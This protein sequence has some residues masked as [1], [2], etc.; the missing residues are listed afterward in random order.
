MLRLLCPAQ[1][2]DWGKP[3][4]TSEVRRSLSSV[5]H[6]GPHGSCRRSSAVDE[7]HRPS[8]HDSTECGNHRCCGRSVETGPAQDGMVGAGDWSLGSGME[9]DEWAPYACHRSNTHPPKPPACTSSRPPKPYTGQ[10]FQ[11]TRCTLS[12][13]TRA[14]KRSFREESHSAGGSYC[15]CRWR[16][17]MRRTR[18]RR[19]TT[20]RTLSCG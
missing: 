17:C 4:A 19:R 12:L 15:I 3:A 7:A 8:E 5:A 18:A 11:A 14:D 16:L 2:Y 10:P 20:R 6:P 9:V 13:P 1:K